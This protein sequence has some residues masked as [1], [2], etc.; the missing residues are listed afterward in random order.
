MTEIKLDI[1]KS[2]EKSAATYFENSKKMRSKIEG[3]LETIERFESQ[4]F[5]LE[6]QEKLAVEAQ[7][8]KAERKLVEKKWFEKFHWFISSEGFL[9]IGGRD[10][11]TNEV[12]IKKHVDKDDLVFHTEA[13]GSPFFV[14]KSEGK[15]PGELTIKECA[16][17]TISYSRA[18]KLGLASADVYWIAPE[19]IS[20]QTETGEYVAKGAFIVRG[21][22]NNIVVEMKLAVGITKDRKIMGG[23]P[24]AVAKNCEKFVNVVQGD[25]KTSDCA[26]K[27]LKIFGNGDLNEVVA[28]LPAGGCR[29][30]V[31]KF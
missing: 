22:K 31:Q 14:I 8:N 2:L 19:Q 6:G 7:K 17:A 3:I 27:I 20:K 25:D 12:I 16:I 26:K 23:A 4:L 29:V 15:K 30:Q 21:K 9:C 18:W 24:S 13:A 5:A 1:R 28:V 10:A 11:T